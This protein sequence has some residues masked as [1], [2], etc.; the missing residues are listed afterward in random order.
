MLFLSSLH[1]LGWLL[2]I[3]FSLDYGP[4]SCFF[5]CLAIFERILNI[6][7]F[8]VLSAEFFTVFFQRVFGFVLVVVKLLKDQLYP[9][10]I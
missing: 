5:V 9:F 2:L 4:F 3:N 10:V 8:A 6:V 1:F 7:Y